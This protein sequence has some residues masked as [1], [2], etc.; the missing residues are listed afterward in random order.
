PSAVSYIPG[1]D[2][3]WYLRR[4][5]GASEVA[6]KKSIFV[7]MAGG[8]GVR[9][10]SNTGVWGGNVFR[11]PFHPG[12]TPGGAQRGLWGQTSFYTLLESAQIVSSI[13][14]SAKAVGAF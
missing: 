8:A 7:V 11:T 2:A 12:E 10:S 9:R 3:A 4:A 1:K 13:A 14:I 5:G 6:N